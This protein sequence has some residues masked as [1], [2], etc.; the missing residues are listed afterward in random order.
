MFGKSRRRRIIHAK[1]WSKLGHDPLN[2]VKFRRIW[3]IVSREP[4][5][6]I[7][8]FKFFNLKIWFSLPLEHLILSQLLRLFLR[9]AF[10]IPSFF[11]SSFFL[12]L[13]GSLWRLA[14]SK[15]WLSLVAGREQPSFYARCSNSNLDYVRFVNIR[16]ESALCHYFTHVLRFRISQRFRAR[17]RNSVLSER[18]HDRP[19]LLLLLLVIAH[20]SKNSRNRIDSL[21]PEQKRLLEG[22][23]PPLPLPPANDRNVIRDQYVS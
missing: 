8:F 7:L 11:P 23:T 6:Y 2:I 5:F 9:S 14:R 16:Y 21:W 13:S 22:C 4:S 3:L 12:Q 15:L 18:E 17:S 10:F 1:R 19:P 20:P